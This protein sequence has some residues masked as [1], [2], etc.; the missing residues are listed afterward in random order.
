[1]L[2]A[3]SATQR[4]TITLCSLS[5]G[6]TLTACTTSAHAANTAS[7]AMTRVLKA[8]RVA[9]GQGAKNISIE[10]EH[11][12]NVEHLEH[13]PLETCSVHKLRDV[14]QGNVQALIQKTSAEP[15]IP[16][17]LGPGA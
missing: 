2:S 12:I 15:R 16:H 10:L 17:A 6:G 5:G 1:M 7:R 14:A 13:S 3:T 8:E 9:E 11:A 4:D